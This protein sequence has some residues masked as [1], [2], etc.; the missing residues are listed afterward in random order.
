MNNAKGVI[1]P[2]RIKKQECGN[3]VHWLIKSEC[4]PER[5]GFKRTY[6]MTPC[7]YY[8]IDSFYYSETP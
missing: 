7:Q 6:H 4:E 1:P 5:N 3:C 8:K 2:V